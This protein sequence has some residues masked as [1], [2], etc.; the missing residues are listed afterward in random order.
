M[1]V[2]VTRDV[3]KTLIM[4]PY[5]YG[6]WASFKGW[7]CYGRHTLQLYQ[8]RNGRVNELYNENTPQLN[9]TT[10]VHTYYTHVRSKVRVVCLQTAVI[11]THTKSTA[12]SP[13]KLWNTMYDNSCK[14]QTLLVTGPFNDFLQTMR[15]CHYTTL[16]TCKVH[17]MD[18]QSNNK[19]QTHTHTN[20]TATYPTQNLNKFF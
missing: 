6:W 3:Y 13:D 20:S 12:K 10:Y 8:Y 7:D 5:K 4:I 19:R 17:V 15:N 2:K 1:L 11:D 14:K 16:S 18:S 9:N